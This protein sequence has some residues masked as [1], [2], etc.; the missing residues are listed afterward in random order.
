LCQDQFF[1]WLACQDRCWTVERLVWHGLQHPPRCP[2]CDQSMETIQHL[3]GCPFLRTIWYEVLPWVRSTAQPQVVGEDFMDWATAAWSILRP[4]CKGTSSM[5]ML[6]AWWIWKNHNTAFFDPCS[7][8]QLAY[9]GRSNPW[10]GHGPTPE[11]LAFVSCSADLLYWV[12]LHGVVFAHSWAW[13]AFLSINASKCK[14]FHFRKE[15]TKFETDFTNV[16]IG[17]TLLVRW[18]TV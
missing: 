16:Q 4:L 7:Q 1:I 5:V 18:H 10:L 11:R 8:T 9:L 12:L 13:M 17:N 3:T 14:V 2:L 15:N 6:T